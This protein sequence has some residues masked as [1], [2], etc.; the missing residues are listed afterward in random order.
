MIYLKI[1]QARQMVNCKRVER[2]YQLHY[3][4]LKIGPHGGRERRR[5]TPMVEAEPMEAK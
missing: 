4:E 2:L 5:R 3:P 1:R